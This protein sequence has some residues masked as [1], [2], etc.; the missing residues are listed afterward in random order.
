MTKTTARSYLVFTLVSLFLF[1]EMGVQV[2]PSVMTTQLM[3]SLAINAVGLGFMSSFY[4]YTYTAM[5][6]PAGMLLDRF[7]VRHIVVVALIVCAFGAVTF[8]LSYSIMSGSFARLLM[9]FGSAFAFVSVLA[10]A[11]R[12]FAAKHFAMLAG[13]AQLFAALGAISGEIPMVFVVENYGWRETM[14]GLAAVS[15][16]LSILVALFV[17][18][19]RVKEEEIHHCDAGVLQGLKTILTNRQTAWVALYALFNWAPMA[20]FASL[21][22]VPFLESAYGLSSGQAASLVSLVWI[23]IGLSSPVIGYWSD[24]IGLR[25]RP[26]RVVTFI[27]LLS[28][29]AVVYSTQLP[30]W[31]LAI[32]LFLMGAACSGQVLSFAVVKDNAPKQARATAIALNNMAVVIS[33]AIFQPL[34]GILLQ[35]HNGT[36]IASAIHYSYLD[37]RYAL[38]VLPLMFLVSFLL[39]VFFIKETHCSAS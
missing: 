20:T 2:S 37:Y 9:G 30:I 7:G 13:L 12:W 1:Y 27:G 21:W 5:Q 8:G 39:S 15:V 33:G 28:A 4:F 22:G 11:S 23:G 6:V 31:L 36:Q 29:M 16:V 24:R 19:K 18:E 3:H 17:R 35:H 34:V 26:L 25:N 10:V 38:V 32:L 14:Y